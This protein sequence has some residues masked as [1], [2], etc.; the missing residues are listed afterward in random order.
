MARE[1]LSVKTLNVRLWDDGRSI[2]KNVSFDLPVGSVGAIVGGSG[3]GKTTLGLAL[4]GLL[5]SA[6][7]RSSGEIHFE[8][9]D[10]ART[11]AQGLRTV[12]GGR[13]GMVFQEP[14]SAFDPVYTIGAQIVE[15]LE[16]HRVSA[17]AEARAR[18]LELLKMCGVPDP[19]RI[20]GSY[21]HELS[22]GLCQRAMIAQAVACG[23]SLLIADEPTSSLDVM[24]QARVIELFRDLRARL[25]LSILLI[26]H[27]LGV[28]RALAD[29]VAVMHKGEIVDKG[30]VE[31]IF[32]GV[33]HPYTT[34]LIAAEKL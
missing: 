1:L 33:R 2:L 23:P 7:W 19:A 5:P 20:A 22:G 31:E 3:S 30:T 8:G 14:M 6:M 32:S 4:L 26:T 25:G 11:S 15:T 27:D 12:R 13:I 10:L 18:T 9:K 16:A 28:A 34:E 17:G 21:P 29:H 24:L